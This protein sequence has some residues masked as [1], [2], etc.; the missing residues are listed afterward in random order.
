MSS[1]L[2]TVGPRGGAAPLTYTLAEPGQVDLA[3]VFAHFDGTSAA[4]SFRPTVTIR[5]QNGTILARVFPTDTLAAGD[6]ADVTYAPFLRQSSTGGGYDTVQDEGAALTQR[7]IIDFAGAGVTAIDDA[8]NS[9]TLVT[10]PGG[11]AG[12]DISCRLTNSTPITLTS[13]VRQSLTFDTEIF[14]T[15]SMHSTTV[16]PERITINTTGKYIVGGEALFTANAVG[17]RDLGIQVNSLGA[18][19][20]EVADTNAGA[21]INQGMTCETLIN[22]TAGDWIDLRARQD[23]GGNL[24]VI[25]QSFYSPIF[26]AVKVG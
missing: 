9:R 13:T 7:Q 14:D 19:V 10:I 23:S 4:G 26:Y 20:V 2:E 1:I 11:G 17:R 6:T 18:F 8:A 22:L 16:N 25:S 24:D 3:S 21:G 12:S 5:A 15:D